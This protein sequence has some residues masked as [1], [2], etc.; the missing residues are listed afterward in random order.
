M[1]TRLE[2]L[3]DG[4]GVINY[5]VAETL[6]RMDRE[7]AAQFIQTMHR[8]IA[9][10]RGESNPSVAAFMAMVIDYVSGDP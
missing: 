5:A 6:R 2:V 8:L 10:E 1:A 4:V 7:Q 3:A 9:D